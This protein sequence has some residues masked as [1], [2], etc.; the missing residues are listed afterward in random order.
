[1]DLLLDLH[2]RRYGV[3]ILLAWDDLPCKHVLSRYLSHGTGNRKVGCGLRGISDL[4]QYMITAGRR[5][6]AVAKPTLP[7]L[8]PPAIAT[9]T[10]ET[11]AAAHKEWA[12]VP[13]HTD[14]RLYTDRLKSADGNTA[15]A[16]GAPSQTYYPR[17]AAKLGPDATSRMASS[18]RCQKASDSWCDKVTKRL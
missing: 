10:K 7:W 15:T 9:T 14:I 18:T 2:S 1:M 5:I 4:M 11:E 16:S 12:K 13:K 6:E 17:D 3:R 8:T